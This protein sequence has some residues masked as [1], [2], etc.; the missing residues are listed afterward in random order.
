M[1]SP[2]QYEAYFENLATKHTDIQHSSSHK[3]FSAINI[4]DLLNDLNGPQEFPAMVLE[5]MSGQIR[6][7][8]NGN[9]V[10]YPD[11]A[12]AILKKVA[13]EDVPGEKQAYQDAYAIGCEIL[14]YMNDEYQRNANTIARFFEPQ[15][16]VRWENV[17][18]VYDNCFGVRFQFT[19]SC[20]TRLK[21]NNAKWL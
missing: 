13:D 5:K 17:G 21:K 1:I 11:G 9:L 19:L 10:Q 7:I 20:G 4:D 15:G 12:F 2:E 18:P 16:G 3:K 6:G 14:A 8:D